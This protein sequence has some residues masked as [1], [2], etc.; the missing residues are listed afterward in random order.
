MTIC[1][2]LQ[3]AARMELAETAEEPNR[4]EYRRQ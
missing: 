1:V 3:E 2:G 4:T